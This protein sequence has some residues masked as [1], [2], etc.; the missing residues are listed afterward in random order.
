MHA[1]AAHPL[2][3]PAA[4]EEQ[5][6]AAEALVLGMKVWLASALLCS[7]HILVQRSCAAAEAL[8]LSMK[9]R[10]FPLARD[11]PFPFCWARSAMHRLPPETW[12]RR[13]AGRVCCY[14][15]GTLS[16]SHL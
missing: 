5:V 3:R 12:S 8:V 9:V 15:W 7:C 16:C 13:G 2:Q 6:A 1:A 14:L 11:F 4:S 10:D